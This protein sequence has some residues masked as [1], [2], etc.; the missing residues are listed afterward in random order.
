MLYLKQSG[1]QANVSSAPVC[2]HR[3]SRMLS[4]RL[5]TDAPNSMVNLTEDLK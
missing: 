4:F 2:R 5:W 3:L 1:R